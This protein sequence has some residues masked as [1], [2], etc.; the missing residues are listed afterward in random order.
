MR[1]VRFVVL[2]FSALGMVI[3]LSVQAQ[4]TTLDQDLLGKLRQLY[5]ESAP[6]TITY[7]GGEKTDS[8]GNLVTASAAN[9]DSAAGVIIS[10][11]KGSLYLDTRPCS[12]HI[13]VFGGRY[14]K[15]R[16]GS[17]SCNGK[18]YDRYEIEAR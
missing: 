15:T 2:W 17:V 7:V 6:K 9:G 3:S 12:G 10:E 4:K 5:G 11:M 13:L 16:L 8:M 18:Q 14:R 1:T